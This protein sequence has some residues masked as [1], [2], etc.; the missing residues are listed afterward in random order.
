VCNLPLGNGEEAA[1]RVGRHFARSAKDLRRKN[2]PRSS[3]LLKGL[4]TTDGEKGQTGQRPLR[5]KTLINPKESPW[6][7]ALDVSR[8]MPRGRMGRGEKKGDAFSLVGLRECL[9]GHKAQESN[10]PVLN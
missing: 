8:G 10:D 6:D 3:H 7:P 2:I 5:R 1:K 9:R 4:Q